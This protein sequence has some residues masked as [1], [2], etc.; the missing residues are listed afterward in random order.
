MARLRDGLRGPTAQGEIHVTSVDLALI[1]MTSAQQHG[2]GRN[3]H[4][5]HLH[6]RFRPS[7][8]TTQ[9]RPQR[10]NDASDESSYHQ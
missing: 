8:G 3:A 10:E 7:R 2:R 4:K 5:T 6:G 9:L 1:Y